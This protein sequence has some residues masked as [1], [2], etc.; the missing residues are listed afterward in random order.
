MSLANVRHGAVLWRGH[1][2]TVLLAMDLG[3]GSMLTVRQLDLPGLSIDDAAV[4]KALESVGKLVRKLVD[5][6]DP[7]VVHHHGMR[8]LEQDDAVRIQIITD[9]CKDGS[10]AAL[11]AKCGALGYARAQAYGLQLLKV[12]FIGGVGVDGLVGGVGGMTS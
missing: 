1:H 12:C 8:V 3:S 2:V 5:E 7:L 10:L 4:L 6:P 11:L 9:Y